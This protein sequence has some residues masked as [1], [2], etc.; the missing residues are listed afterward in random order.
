MGGCDTVY[1]INLSINPL[2]T[3]AIDTSLCQGQLPYVFSGVHY[4][5]ACTYKDTVSST[6]GGCDTA[7]TINLSIN[8][9]LTAAIDTSLCQ[10]QL[11]Y[12]FNGVQYNTAGTYKDT[13]SST[14][15][16][17]DTD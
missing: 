2:L 3:A 9:L 11:P 1:T 15:G 8:P 13:V 12:V 16:G 6:T 17:C 4:N 10:G 14:T 7:Y 5:A